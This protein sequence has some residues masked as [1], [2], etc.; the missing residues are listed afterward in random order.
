MPAS[1]GTTAERVLLRA[2]HDVLLEPGRPVRARVQPCERR[3]EGARKRRRRN[4]G[5]RALVVEQL[6]DPAGAI[7]V[8]DGE[9]ALEPGADDDRVPALHGTRHRGEIQEAAQEDFLTAFRR[10][11]DRARPVR[12]RQDERLGARLQELAR[13]GA[14]VETRDPNRLPLA[15]HERVWDLLTQGSRLLD[16]GAAQH[17]PIAGGERLG[18]GRRRPQD[19]DDDA[20]PRG[21]GRVGGE[22]NVDAHRPTTLLRT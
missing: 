20:D 21:T 7:G 16:L 13:R 2:E 1:R 19:V 18:D 6:D 15:A 22:S 10:L 11:E 14:D 5:V 9:R 4:G 17:P 3:G 12:R 8:V